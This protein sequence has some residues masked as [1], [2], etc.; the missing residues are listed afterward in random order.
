MT[1]SEDPTCTYNFNVV[2]TAADLPAQATTAA[3]TTTSSAHC[4]AHADSTA[5]V[6]DS[7][8]VWLAPYCITTEETGWAWNA[9]AGCYSL[10]EFDVDARGNNAAYLRV[11][12]VLTAQVATRAT[13]DPAQY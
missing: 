8:C 10:A 1:V 3:P 6:S 13:T 5:C 12:P 11:D 2:L 4:A 7:V 9:E